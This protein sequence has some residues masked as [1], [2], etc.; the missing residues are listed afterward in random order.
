MIVD[1]IKRE[2]IQNGKAK[3]ADPGRYIYMKR[4]VNNFQFRSLI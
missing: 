4:Q 3:L 1:E 2:I